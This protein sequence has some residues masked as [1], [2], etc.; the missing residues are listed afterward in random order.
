M[1]RCGSQTAGSGL[2]KATKCRLRPNGG[3]RPPQTQVTNG[4]VQLMRCLE[5]TPPMNLVAHNNRGSRRY[6][7]THLDSS[8]W[9]I[10]TRT[11][12][13]TGGTRFPCGVRRPTP[14]AATGKLS[15]TPEKSN[16]VRRKWRIS[17]FK[18]RYIF[19]Y[20]AKNQG[21]TIISKLLILKW[22]GRGDLNP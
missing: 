3:L 9:R 16:D 8:I 18:N 19:H 21:W 2:Y 20:S 22:C 5:M 14:G 11:A 13:C 15:P 17:A 4:S 6:P 10:V 7:S 1:S 12:S